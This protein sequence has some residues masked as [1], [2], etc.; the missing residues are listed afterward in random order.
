[1]K[2]RD[3]IVYAA[4]EL[5]NQHGERNITT[6]HIADHIE[7]SP[8]N[9]YYHFR[10]KQEI[11]REIF[12]LYSAELLE[13]FTPIQGSQ[14]SLT[15]LKSY[16]D[17]IFTLMWKYR[18]FY[19][20]LPEILSRDEQLHEHYIDVQEKLQ[21]NL[22]AIMQEFVSLKLLDVNEQQLK[23]LVCTLHLIACSWLAYQSAMASKTSITEQMVKQ[24]MLQMLNVVKPVA[25]E[26]GLEQLQLLE[27]AV[28]T[29]QG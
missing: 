8:G 26:Q 3:K 5:F 17:S 7:I 19:A 29:L 18:F 22:I 13:R 21:A 25:T 28:S 20:N 9:L 2:T 24:G 14:E 27:E 4:L 11:V 12:A 6:N 23:S 15:M 16:L 10:N 1:M